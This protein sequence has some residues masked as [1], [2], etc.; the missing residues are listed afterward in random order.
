MII[1]LALRCVY[2]HVYICCATF[3]ELL[4]V[5]LFFKDQ[6]QHII[7]FD[8]VMAM[9]LL[10]GHLKIDRSVAIV[11]GPATLLIQ[12]HCMWGQINTL[13]SH[14][15]SKC[16]LWQLAKQLLLSTKAGRH[17][18]WVIKQSMYMT[19]LCLRPRS[20]KMIQFYIKLLFRT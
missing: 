20:D 11:G 19:C 15:V 16:V 10:H 18:R 8:F 6:T 14:T 3:V 7:Y 17:A 13:A 1:Y 12:W 2:N 9:W 5:L 4:R